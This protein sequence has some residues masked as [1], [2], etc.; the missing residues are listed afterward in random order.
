[1]R[2]RAVAGAS[3]AVW[4]LAGCGGGAS[5]PI[6]PKGYDVTVVT[7][8]T[9][10]DGADAWNITGHINPKP[11]EVDQYEGTG[12][13]S[14]TKLLQDLGSGSDKRQVK[15]VSGGAFI[16][17]SIQGSNLHI[18]G[19]LNEFPT[20]F[21]GGTVPSGGGK[22]ED[23]DHYGRNSPTESGIAGP[24]CNV[25]WKTEVKKTA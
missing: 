23:K 5:G 24:S 15:P 1:M 3:A 11:D 7:S 2:W 19:F 6:A 25:T 17:G 8:E 13:Y 21:F 10:E 9:C 16:S 12:Q 20:Q 18:L 14:G 22:G 4:L